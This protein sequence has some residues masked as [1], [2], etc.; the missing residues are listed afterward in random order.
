MKKTNK[1]SAFTLIELLIVIAIIGILA[2]LMFPAINGAL[3]KANG[4]KLGNNGANIVKSILSTNIDLEQMSKASIWP[5][6]GDGGSSDYSDANTYFAY[7]MDNEYLDGI[8]YSM[9]AGGGVAAAQDK[10]KLK[11][12]GNVWNVLANVDNADD[13]IPFLWTRNLGLAD[14][15]ITGA[16]PDKSVNWKSKLSSDIKPFGDVQV[17]LVRKGGAMQ[18][19]RN[20]YLFSDEFM[21]GTTNDAVKILAA[22]G[23]ANN[24]G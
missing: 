8:S 9:F 18:T 1:L 21:G 16:S 4:V 3:N 5:T 19:I 7:L 13:A 12:E 17:V 15:D 6:K 23:G 11:T 20:K 22:Q 14:S 2:T 24:G 10:D